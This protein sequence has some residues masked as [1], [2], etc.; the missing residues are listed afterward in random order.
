MKR[1]SPY[2]KMRVLGAIDYAPGNS[3]IARI[4]R[5]ASQTFKDEDGALLQFTWRTIQTWYSRYKKD[6]ITSMHPRTRKDKGRC[7]K[8][9]PEAVHEAIQQA[10]PAFHTDPPNIAAVYKVCIESGYLAPQDVA[11]TTFRRIVKQHELLAPE[12]EHSTKRRL[13]FAK[14][15][16]GDLW[17]AVAWSALS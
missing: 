11:V 13:A 15:H 14:P 7:R 16:P 3:R 17:Q 10:L 6:G 8:V 1:V 12:D 4:V 2:L 9:T 5:V